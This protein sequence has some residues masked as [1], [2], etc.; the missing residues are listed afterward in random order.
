MTG[1]TFAVEDHGTI[2]QL[3]VRCTREPNDTDTYEVPVN[4]DHRMF[5]NMVRDRGVERILHQDVELEFSGE[6][7]GPTLR[8]FDEHDEDCQSPDC[9]LPY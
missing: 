3:W 6:P 2:V 5:W 1:R 4:F 7:M 8:F 9:Q